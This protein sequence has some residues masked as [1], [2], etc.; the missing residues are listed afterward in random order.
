MRYVAY[1]VVTLIGLVVLLVVGTGFAV[2]AW[3]PELAR[4][5]IEAALTTALGRE[6]HVARVDIEFWHGRVVVSGVTA[7]ARPDEPGPNALTLSRVE[8]QVGVTSL[9]RRRLV[10][11]RVRLDDLD[12]RLGGGGG[13]GDVAFHEIPMLPEV[14]QAGP[15]DVELGTIEVRRARLAYADSPRGVR[16][17][18]LGVS[19]TAWR[20]RDATRLQIAADE[21]SIETPDIKD[22]VERLALEIR[23]SPISIQLRRLVT[24]W[25]RRQ[26]GVTGR[27]D[28]PFGDPTLDLTARGDVALEPVGR[29]FG[30]AWPLDG[31]VHTTARIQ[32][33]TQAL[34]VAADVTSKEVRVASVTAHAIT[35]HFAIADRVVSVRSLKAR[36]FDGSVSGDAVV[37]LGHAE[38]SHATVTLRDIASGM[39]EPLAGLQTGIRARLDADVHA[40]GNLR[41]LVRARTRV[42]VAAR[43]VQLPASLAPLGTGTV[44]AEAAGE[45]GTFDLSNVVAS[46]PGLRLEARGRAT[47]E[48]PK[49]LHVK[50]T[51]DLARLAPLLGP[52]RAA[53]DVALDAE[54]TGRWRDPVVAGRLDVRSPTVANL[55]ADAVAAAFALTSRS[56]RLTDASLHLG[57]SRVVAAGNLAWPASNPPAV[58]APDVVS[59]DLVARTEQVHVE[60]ATPWLPIALHGSSGPVDVTAR[61]DGTL[62][63]WHVSGQVESSSLSLPSA[64]AISEVRASFDIAPE[65]IAVG[66]LRAR[67][68]DGAVSAKGRWRWAGSGE[69]EAEAG[70]LDL[71]RL[72]GL[73]E[74]LG[75]EGRGRVTVSATVRDGTVAGSVRA[76]ADGVGVAGFSLGRGVARV[77]SDG[78]V[79][80]GEAEFPEARI[81][82]TGQVR[83]QDEAVIATRVT[84]TDLEVEPLLRTYRPDLV[85]M[86]AGRFSATVALD[87]PARNPRAARGVIRLE[88]VEVD[89]GGEHWDV[90]GPVVIRREPGRLTLERL[91]LSGRL[92]TATAS[93]RLE[94]GG[95]LEGAVRGQ[96]PLALLSVFRPEIREASGRLDIDVRIG[97][98]TAN[99]TLLGRGTIADGVLALRDTPVVVRD[100]DARVALVPTR[101]R[102]EELKARVGGG[103][104]SATG[105]IALD[106]GTV[107][108]YQLALTGRNL[109]VTALEGLET[110]WN[111]DAT[112]VGRGARGLVRG[113]AHLVRG[114]YTRDLSITPMLLK[115]RAP[116]DPIE[117]GRELALQVDLHLDDNLVVRSPQA[118]LRAG[119]TLRLR[120]TVSRPTVLGT[121]AT[122]EGRVTFRR[123]VFTLENA[124]VRFDDPRGLNP[125]LDVRATTRIRT[126]DV[127]MRLTGRVDDLSIRLTSEP[128]L[129]QEDL[130]ALVTLGAT[131]AE[132]GSSGGLTFAG[133][134]AQMLSRE[135]LGLDTSTPF[136]DIVDF[137]RSETGQNEFRV[138]KRLN[139]QTT[140]I[141]SGSFAE[142]GQ[143]KLRI[144][145][146]VL[147][148]LL[149]AGEQEFSGGF[150]GDVILRLRFR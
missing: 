88:P 109:S 142:G 123:N 9:W 51:G 15:V 46:W 114:T 42:R 63:A 14:V 28:G 68:L 137:R 10:L 12:L 83:L 53:G 52:T 127:T 108:A 73:P 75:V 3:G 101:L 57:R 107:G 59:L 18:A 139:D 119:G 61:I 77:S 133:E 4:E 38:R 140:V 6:A 120:S 85:G 102:I 136:V 56:L 103:T 116:Q 27:I 62:S 100:I 89:A 69:I 25:E 39:L 1:V 45:Q 19:G 96:A 43:G 147:G 76:M 34:R 58:P 33:R 35:A 95:T 129:P 41:D 121:I 94:D 141:Y 40:R 105:E 21:I 60:D 49:P 70:P 93:G 104:L 131:R 72:P 97:G 31:I 117:W 130:L 92:G 135:L 16:A 7:T 118:R 132:L 48:G 91:E 23:A 74:G 148:P 99:P 87:V 106:R 122:Q 54:I 47:L 32:G 79:V 22:R 13:G 150:G 82:A 111:A 145:Y 67:V 125:Y 124:V 115:E 149:V 84:A 90:R 37:D 29:R 20:E 112:L 65:Q 134:A 144:E 64:P 24:I 143:Q 71:A 55:R 11:R 2:R 98:T 66:T 113:D 138:G 17:T 146:Q 126:Y 26:V 8:A 5:R 81:A 30:V 78:T 110:V 80:R 128:P 50:A 86:V 44:D 36:V